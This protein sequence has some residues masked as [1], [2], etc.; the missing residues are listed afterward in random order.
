MT[1]C[2]FLLASVALVALAACAPKAAAPAETTASEPAA[3]PMQT[4]DAQA[5][6][7]ST[8]EMAT[9]EAAP[10][11]GDTADAGQPALE[12]N[13]GAGDYQSYVGTNASALTL[14]ADLPH[15]IFGPNDAVTMDYAPNRLNFRTD[16]DGVILEVKCG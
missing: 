2:K 16:E 5:D 14:P 12:D 9:D 6:D 7:M 3:A 15:R 4:D 11:E 10:N 1:D 8:D 13:C